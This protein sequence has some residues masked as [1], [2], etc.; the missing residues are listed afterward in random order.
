MIHH[1]SVFEDGVAR[2]AIDFALREGRW[3]LLKDG[4]RPFLPS[5]EA[6]D[7]GAVDGVIGSFFDP[8]WADAVNRAGVAAVNTSTRHAGMPLPRVGND[9]EEIGRVGAQHLLERGFPQF[10][11][12][13]VEDAWFSQR[14]LAGFRRLLEEGAGRT[15]A[16]LDLPSGLE[17]APA[18]VGA[19]L[20]RQPRPVAVMAATD[21]LGLMAL[22][23]ATQLGLRIPD[24]VAVL[25]V[26]N[27]HWAAVL[28]PVPMSSV[29]VNAR[30]IGFRAA[31]LLDRLM[32]GGTPPP[33]RWIPPTGVVT[34]QSTDIVVHED[35]VVA[36]AMKHIREHCVEPIG[37]DDVPDA[38]GVSRRTLERRFKQALGLTPLAAIARARVERAKR[39]LT[40]S[41]ETA[42]RIAG[43]C[44]FDRQE[45]FFRVFKR[46]TGL[47]P[48]QFRR[49]QAE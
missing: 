8:R 25:G 30:R 40:E 22:N 3:R 10:A 33:P 36:R 7:L 44:G 28:A 45:R 11:F 19:W 29:A 2:G 5:F 24:D 49:R 13:G 4:H 12:L 47:T 31:E 34:R 37:V 18:R 1:P 35:P 9:D 41:E 14:R 43:L 42:G 23:A 20:A 21:Y 46:L 17:D 15:C 32:R 39:M 27:D 16:T 48:G 6:M 38:I 26:D